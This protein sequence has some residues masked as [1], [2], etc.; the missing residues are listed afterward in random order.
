M[1]MNNDTATIDAEAD[2]TSFD[3]AG[4]TLN[5]TTNDAV[6]TQIGYLA[7]STRRRVIVSDVPGADSPSGVS[8]A[9][10]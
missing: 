4:F 2:V 5:W 9:R 1:K 10:R 6:A 3:S 7:L 8:L